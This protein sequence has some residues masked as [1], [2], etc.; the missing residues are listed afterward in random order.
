MINEFWD[1]WSGREIQWRQRRLRTRRLYLDG[2]PRPKRKNRGRRRA[3]E[4]QRNLVKQLQSVRHHPLTG[5]VALDLNFHVTADQP[6]ALYK[7]AKY[8]MDVLGATQSEG[9][10][11]GRRRVLYRD[12]CQVKLLYVHLW[13]PALGREAAVNA[14]GSGHT[15]L[16]ARPLRDVVEDI[17]LLRWLE[18][19]GDSDVDDDQAPFFRPE[20]PHLEPGLTFDPSQATSIEEAKRWADLNN[21]LALHDRSLLQDAVLRSTDADVALLLRQFP[22]SIEGARPQ[23]RPLAANTVIQTIYEQL[24]ALHVQNR[25]SLL[26]SPIAVPLPSLPRG[27][28]ERQRF[29]ANIRQE[30]EQWR[31]RWP[32]FQTLLVPL[33]VTFLVIPAAE[34]GRDLDNIAL[35]VLPLVHDV[36]Q[37]LPDS[38]LRRFPLPTAQERVEATKNQRQLRFLS[39]SSVTAFE[40]IELQRRAD[41]PPSGLLRLALGSGNEI[42]STWTRVTDYVEQHMEEH[43]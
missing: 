30:L 25:D 39:S 22:E 35:D 23:R 20:I 36:L 2:E 12:D 9:D 19:D 17:R 21:W 43:H 14:K 31:A 7:L 26:S 11:G 3:L 1:N 4:A 6:P 18:A 10:G 13:H 24:D 29:K 8:L 34:Q 15:W 27:S 28:N 42:G 5:P 38:W 37:P 32:V 40:V 16:T 41:D 33:K